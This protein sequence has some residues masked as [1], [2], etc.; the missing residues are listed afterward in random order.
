M[1]N[2]IEY[3]ARRRRKER[4]GPGICGSC[5]ALPAASL[6]GVV[7]V[8]VTLGLLRT[9]SLPGPSGS[10][11]HTAAATPNALAGI[12][13]MN[14]SELSRIDVATMNLL[15]AQG[16]SPAGELDVE[17]C[18]RTLDS[19][20]DRVRTETERH[21]YRF[22]QNPPEFEHSEGFFRMLML[23][24]VL[25]EDFSV[26]YNPERISTP[27]SLGVDDHFFGDP[28]DVFLHGLV[29]REGVQGPKSKA[30]SPRSKVQSLGSP[31]P[32][33][34]P[35][36]RA[37]AL[38]PARNSQLSTLNRPLGTCS[39]MPVLYLAIGRRLGYPLKRVTTKAHLFVRWEGG[40]ERFNIEATGH[41]LN[42]FEDDYYRHWPLEV[43]PAEEAAE[44]YLKSLAP[45]EEL[46]VF[47]ST[48]GMCLREAGRLPE[49][50]EAFAAAARRAPA[51]QGY[52]VMLAS[53]T[54]RLGPSSPPVK[55]QAEETITKDN[56]PKL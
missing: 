36:E 39:S 35:E 55:P 49:A 28:R 27:G 50:A 1:T 25:Q 30:Q 10:P 52:Q 56:S 4:V 31:S 13:A 32:Y 11:H 48:R 46:A 5:K 16:L 15:C 33:P 2:G 18:L 7:G 24:V 29:G 34:L 51:C 40:G 45:P 19:W 41:G 47:L 14:Q 22:R 38:L 20:A 9:R 8:L 42:R 53:L 26:R 37:T 12:L 54:A 17:Q 44:G 43:T 3:T 21:W 23:A 6:V